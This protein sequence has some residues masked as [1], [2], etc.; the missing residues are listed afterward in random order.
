MSRTQSAFHRQ[1]IAIV[2]VA[3]ATLLIVVQYARLIEPAAAREVQAACKG[4]RPAPDNP[5]FG[6]IPSAQPV[7][8]RAQNHK[9]EIVSLSDYRGKIVFVNFWA[10][11]CNVCKT[12][13]PSLESMGGLLESDD[14]V[15]LTLASNGSWD[16]IR[17]Y[18]P[19]GSPLTILLDPPTGSDNLGTIAKSYGITAVPE[20]FVI[21]RDGRILGYYINKRDWSSGIAETCLRAIIDDADGA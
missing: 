17:E 10:T 3:A 2:L 20:S 8:F 21:G 16:D 6:A 15:V 9:G 4:L 19:Q 5:M 18:Y 14:Y 13:K 7:D 1:L 12:E 11:W